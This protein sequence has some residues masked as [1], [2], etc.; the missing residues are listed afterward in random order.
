MMI[1]IASGTYSSIFIASPVLTAWKEREPQYIRRRQR[2]A[3]VEGGLVPAFADDVQVAM[4]SA[5]SETEEEVAPEELQ[6]AAAPKRKRLGGAVA[7]AEPAANGDAPEGVVAPEPR[8]VP[9]AEAPGAPGAGEAP[10]AA[11]T[12]S[13]ADPES[14]ARRKRN[15]ERRAKRAQRRKGG[16]RR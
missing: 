3:E 5:D 9:R 14:A 7:T 13:D 11:D 10:P 16:R 15:D 2:I 4:L 6:R 1:G 12:G 8:V